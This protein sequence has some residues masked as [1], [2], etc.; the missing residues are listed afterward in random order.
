MIGTILGT[1][2]LGR[3]VSNLTGSTWVQVQS[4][5]QVVEAI[6]LVGCRKGERV[7]VISGHAVELACQ[8]CAAEYAVAA[9]LSSDGNNG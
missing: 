2:P 3:T 6:D 7:L 9:V 4:Q 8:G 5:G 1:L